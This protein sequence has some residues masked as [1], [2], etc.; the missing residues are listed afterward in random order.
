MDKQGKLTTIPCPNCR[1]VTNLTEKGV[2]GLQ[3]AFHI[4]HL[5]EIREGLTNTEE[6]GSLPGEEKV[7][8][9]ATAEKRVL[10][11]PEHGDKEMEIF[12][13][14]CQQLA[15]VQCVYQHHHDHEHNLVTEIYNQHKTELMSSLKPVQEYQVTLDNSI[16]QL[17]VRLQD[18]K[19]RQVLAKAEIDV[20]FE[21]ISNQVKARKEEVVAELNTIA[22]KKLKSVSAQKERA[23]IMADK[24]KGCLEFVE[25]SLEVSEQHFMLM[26]A[27]TVKQVEELVRYFKP[28]LLLEP[29]EESRIKFSCNSEEFSACLKELGCVYSYDA[30]PEKCNA[31]GLG[32]EKAQV[33]EKSFVTVQ[34]VNSRDFLCEEPI[35]SLECE[36]ISEIADSTVLGTVQQK[37][38]SFRTLYDIEYVPENKGRHQLLIKV[39][40]EHIRGSPFSVSVKSSEKIAKLILSIEGFQWPTGIAI[41][42]EGRIIVTESRGNCISICAPNG[43]K[44]LTFG[45][46]E[47]KGTGMGQFKDLRG[48]VLDPEGNILVLD[49]GNHKI[50]T[51]SADGKFLRASYGTIGF[52]Y[53][54]GIALNPVNSS[55][56]ITDLK[57]HCVVVLSSDFKSV[58][59]FSERGS[60]RGQ[61]WYPSSVTCDSDGRVYVT[62][63][64]NHRVQVF[65]A[66]GQY[67]RR[68]GKVGQGEGC[69]QSPSGISI[70]GDCVYVSEQDNHRLSVFSTEGK[71]VSTIGDGLLRKPQGVAVDACGVLFI[72]D[73]GNDCV[74][75]F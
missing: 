50:L 19:T 23:G 18:I 11:C 33:G 45:G 40:G 31:S 53:P 48:V 58:S 29:V 14:S 74:R 56:Y 35:R 15:C 1:Q 5:F 21:Q 7:Q 61:L 55:Y 65:S 36:L 32:L 3:S 44:L 22:E 72:C 60:G 70:I 34:A 39:E 25:G 57:S 67:L 30:C 27:D 10:L 9:P 69:L 51:F 75:M 42:G 62:D 37:D 68:F 63:S 54:T 46:E 38:K 28:R 71:F 66:D 24:V 12:C 59:R 47:A 64:G 41:S 13:L 8:C 16:Q 4:Y 2:S 26:K 17:D 52:N 20:A 73:A 43:D 49:A 6:S